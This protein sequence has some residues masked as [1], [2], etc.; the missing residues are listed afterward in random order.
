MAPL[1]MG[2]S[3]NQFSKSVLLYID[4]SEYPNIIL[5][6]LIMSCWQKIV[7][8]K[9]FGACHFSDSFHVYTNSLMQV[10]YVDYGNIDWVP[11][12]EL[13]L[14]KPEFMNLPFQAVEC[15]LAGVQMSRE[16]ITDMSKEEEAR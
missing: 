4:C 8:S 10:Y 15:Y 5:H 3:D 12:T 16:S 2:C 7:N 14:M 9:A 1:C 11:K 13:R 6:S